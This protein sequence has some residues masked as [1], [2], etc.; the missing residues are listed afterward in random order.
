[1]H[2]QCTVCASQYLNEVVFECLDFPFGRIASMVVV[3]QSPECQAYHFYM[4][5]YLTIMGGVEF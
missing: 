4:T 3:H 5:G 1:M 2:S